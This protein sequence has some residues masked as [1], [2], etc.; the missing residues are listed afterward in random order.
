MMKK[1]KKNAALLAYEA[2]TV[3]RYPD[4]AFQFEE[5]YCK[6][7]GGKKM[8]AIDQRKRTKTAKLLDKPKKESDKIAEVM[9]A[10]EAEI[11]SAVKMHGPMKSAHEGWAVP[12]EEVEELWDQVK[13]KDSKR[14][15]ANMREEAIQIAAMACRL[16]V[17]L[18]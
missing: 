4:G 11:F 18:L 1:A 3:K 9:K 16:V 7:V 15:Q 8:G 12:F 6:N 10:V 2:M 14:S 5:E 17:D 13:L